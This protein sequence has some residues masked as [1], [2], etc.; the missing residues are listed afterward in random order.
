VV[1]PAPAQRPHPPIWVG[2]NSLA[3]LRRTVAH[4][5]GWAPMPSPKAAEG[6]LGTPGIESTDDLAARITRLRELAA[7]AGRTD[8]IDVAVIP[9][10][11]S[12]FRHPDGRGTIDPNLVVD[13]ISALRAV[14]AT[15]LVVNL[16]GGSTGAFSDE[17]ARFAEEVL[18]KI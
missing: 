17:V 5:N 4:G 18:P 3:A 13:E 2:G 1:A 8:P 15:A 12:G 14:G 16:P 10:S 6:L 9:P 11:L 7:D